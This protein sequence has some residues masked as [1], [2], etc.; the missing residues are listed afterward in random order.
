MVLFNYQPNMNVATIYRLYQRYISL[1]NPKENPN[2]IQ[3][4]EKC[5]PITGQV[6]GVIEIKCK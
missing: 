6:I 4:I 3:C 5:D 2:L 1:E